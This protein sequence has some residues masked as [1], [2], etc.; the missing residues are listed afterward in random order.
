MVEKV[1]GRDQLP[2]PFEA[3]DGKRIGEIWFEPPP[4]QS[5][6]LVKYLF[7]SEKLSVQVHPGEDAARDGEDS[8]EECWLVLD[9]QPGARLAAGFNEPITPEAMGRAAEDGTIEE[10]LTWHEVSAGDIFHLTPGTVHA[11]GPGLSLVEV[12][13]N[14]DTTFRLYDYGRPRELHLERALDVAVGAPF[15]DSCK[16]TVKSREPTLIN[17]TRFRLDRIKGE[18]DAAVKA[19]YPGAALVLP[20]EG[21]VTAKDSDVC[22]R[23]GECLVAPSLE[24]LDFSAA[25]LT[26]LTR[27]V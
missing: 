15:P 27:S 13:Q 23:E 25:K 17:G 22:A 19:A 18:P 6:L 11:I 5:E 1:W 2:A 8:K 3:P 4:E 10:L 20:L 14:S 16:G 24:A 26:L 7:T 12:Q 21:T 9:A